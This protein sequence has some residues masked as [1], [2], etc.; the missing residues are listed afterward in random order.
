MYASAIVT[1]EEGDQVLDVEVAIKST[2][3]QAYIKA[4]CELQKVIVSTLNPSKRVAFFL[5]IYQSMYVHMFFKMISEGRQ[6]ES[7]SSM[8]SRISSF[9]SYGRKKAFYYNIAGEDYTI[10]DIKH[11]ML[12]GNQTKPGHLMRILSKSDNKT[13][14]LPQV[15]NPSFHCPRLTILSRVVGATGPS[16]QLH[17][18]GLPRLRRAHPGDCGRRPRRTVRVDEQLRRRDHQR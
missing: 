18:P 3:Y 5:N 1:D 11:G 9:V 10:D 17:L 15:S 8:M 4:V 7:E 16:S 2:E 6:G 13:Q 12:R 14:I